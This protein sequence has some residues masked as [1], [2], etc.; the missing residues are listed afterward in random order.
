MSLLLDHPHIK[1]ASPHMTS[2]YAKVHDT[3]I[4][5]A[6][7]RYQAQRINITGQRI[8]YD[9][10]AP[11]ASAEW[12]KHN[13]NRVRDSLPNGYCARPAQQDCPHPKPA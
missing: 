3:T 1:H 9:P 2:H 13:L 10:D 11:T 5:E 6:F 7:D 12:V 4:R 8:G